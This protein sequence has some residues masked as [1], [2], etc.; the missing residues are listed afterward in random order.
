[1]SYNILLVDDDKEFREEFCDCME[2]F[3]VI[4]AANGAEALSLL[5]APNE[6]DLVL[7]DVMMPG[8]RGT[9]VLQEM[10]KIDPE[11][12]IIILT[13][14]SSKDVAVEA[15]KGRADDYIEKPVDINKL[16]RTIEKVMTDKGIG[17]ASFTQ[18]LKG[19]IERVKRF[20]EKNYDKKVGLED[21]A[22]LVAL[23]PK[24]LSRVFKQDTGLGF[25]E[26]R[27]KIKIRKAKE[28]LET[29]PLSIDQISD[30]LAYQNLESFIRIFKQLA[31]LTPTEYRQKNRK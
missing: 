8:L 3:S 2:G 21:A 16:K 24:Y 20:A 5:K 25:S 30:E 11:L 9:K 31:G 27:L 15:L 22:E 10:K 12:G 18:D 23:S 13:G 4:E 29:T 19:K 1:M 28:L 6:V 14:Y 7:L 17:G 26:Y